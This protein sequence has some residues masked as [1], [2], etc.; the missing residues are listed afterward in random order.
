M[1]QPP[2]A[3]WSAQ[4]YVNAARL[5][6]YVVVCVVSHAMAKTAALLRHWSQLS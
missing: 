1:H 2:E 4:S 3:E 6:A 5:G